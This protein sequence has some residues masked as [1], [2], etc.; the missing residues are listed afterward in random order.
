MSAF[1]ELILSDLIWKAWDNGEHENAA[2]GWP[3]SG[4]GSTLG[5][6]NHHQQN[7]HAF[8]EKKFYLE[9]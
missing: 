4:S 3:K 2:L 8:R 7:K 9:F 6:Q 5:T 1:N